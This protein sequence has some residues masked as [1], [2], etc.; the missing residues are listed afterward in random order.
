M[1][2]VPS[3]AHGTP[4]HFKAVAIANPSTDARSNAKAKVP[5]S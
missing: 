4:E 5:K 2:D 1:R 3:T